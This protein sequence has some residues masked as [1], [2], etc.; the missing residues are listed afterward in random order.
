MPL[1]KKAKNQLVEQYQNKLWQAKNVIVLKQKNIS[2][3]DINDLRIQTEEQSSQ[4]NVVKKKIFLKS[5]QETGYQSIELSVLDWSIVLLYLND[6]ENY[7][8]LK[9]IDKYIK[10]NKKEQKLWS[11]EFIGGWFDK[12]WK[13]SDYV[14]TLATL[15][16]KEELVSKFL[17]LLQFP[18]QWTA[19]VLDKIREK[20]ESEASQ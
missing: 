11:F 17:Y 16:S 10:T 2:V 19:A 12:S 8:P 1:S 20:K 13:N 4:F 14:Q 18:L 15:P 9:V 7:S 3:N 6:A 5:L